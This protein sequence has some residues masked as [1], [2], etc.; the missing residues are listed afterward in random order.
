MEAETL[1]GAI[2]GLGF[3]H[4][5]DRLWQINFYR[6]LVMG[7]LAELIGPMGVPIY[8]YVMSRLIEL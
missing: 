3:I 6:Y 4:A 8:R 2:F 5:K 1:E 7:R